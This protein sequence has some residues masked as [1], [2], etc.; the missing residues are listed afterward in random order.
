MKY[1]KL[2]TQHSLFAKSKNAIHFFHSEFILNIYNRL[3]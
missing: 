2:T 1:N 3:W